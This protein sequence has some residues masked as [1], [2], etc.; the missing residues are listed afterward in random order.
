M[1][2]KKISLISIISVLILFLIAGC[3]N[4]QEQE[5][6]KENEILNQ[7]V[8]VNVTVVKPKSLSE[9][10]SYSGSLEGVDQANIVAKIAERVVKIDKQVDNYVNQGETVIELDKTGPSSQFLQA[11]ANFV[12][13][14]K[15]LKRMQALL[16]AGAISQQ[17]LD[18][19]QTAYDIAKANFEAAKSTVVLTSPISGIITNINVNEGDW[20][21]PGMEMA[22][23]AKINRM[24]IKFFVSE[25]E[26]QDLRLGDKVT[27]WSESKPDLKIRGTITEISKSASSDSRTFQVKAEFPNTKDWWFKPGMFVRVKATLATKKDVVAIPNESI[28][29]MDNKELVYVI[30]DGKPIE[31]DIKTG[32]TDGNF[33]EVMNGMSKGDSLIT[34]GMENITAN[35]ILKITKI[36][37]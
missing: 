16:D 9:D 28:M 15:N 4:K 34:A 21:N 23:I 18:Q 26:I 8:P 19:T 11:Q 2:T 32:M 17:Q 27:V 13:A 36:E 5:K 7:T 30:K 10:K 3:S 12:N 22:T 31:K 33:S 35:S 25:N 24:I 37:E 14:E 29:H 1:R 20:V 6:L